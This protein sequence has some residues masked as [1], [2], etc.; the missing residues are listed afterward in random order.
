MLLWCVVDELCLKEQ[1]V[2]DSH[3]DL[4]FLAYSVVFVFEQALL[5]MRCQLMFFERTVS[6]LS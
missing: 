1:L 4:P 2:G 5:L 3:C 6:Y